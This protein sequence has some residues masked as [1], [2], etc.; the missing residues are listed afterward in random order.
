MGLARVAARA[1]RHPPGLPLRAAPRRSEAI[2]PVP[3]AAR[4]SPWGASYFVG[5]LGSLRLPIVLPR[6]PATLLSSLR[7]RGSGT[8]ASPPPAQPWFRPG[9]LP[10]VPR[11]PAPRPDR[12]L[13]GS[14]PAAG[15]TVRPAGAAGSG[16]RGATIE[17]RLRVA[18]SG[19]RARAG[20]TGRG[21]GGVEG[22][23]ERAERR[24][25]ESERESGGGRGD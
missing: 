16:L 3:I 12:A 10:A 9:L 4:L 6:A 15:G 17:P 1:R 21:T 25:G 2:F 19:R 8:P 11:P 22:R 13:G 18:A 14:V 5:W 20:H 7:L 23:R 24:G